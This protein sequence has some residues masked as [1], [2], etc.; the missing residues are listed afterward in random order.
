M[1]YPIRNKK[2]EKGKKISLILWKISILDIVLVEST[3]KT[4]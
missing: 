2:R 4:K 1:Y 3:R